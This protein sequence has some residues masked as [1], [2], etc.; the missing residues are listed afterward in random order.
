MADRGFEIEDLMLIG[1]IYLHFYVA[2][3]NCYKMN[4]YPLEELHPY[5]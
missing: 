3:S 2:K 1:V 5:R 4:L